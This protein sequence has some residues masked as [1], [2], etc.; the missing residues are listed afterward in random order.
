[1]LLYVIVNMKVNTP[2][3]HLGNISGITHR[4]TFNNSSYY[5]CIASNRHPEY[6]NG[7]KSVFIPLL[8]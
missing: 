7:Y 8:V 6:E 2:N 1:M 5:K 4:L 3:A